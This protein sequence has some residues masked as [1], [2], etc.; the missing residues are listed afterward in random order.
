MPIGG[1]NLLEP[2][3]LGIAAL[4]GPYNFNAVDIAE[5]LAA[6]GAVEILPDADALAPALIRLLNDPDERARRGAAGLN[7]VA[8]SREPCSA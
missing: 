5:L 3:S 7:T 2:A 4:T 1:H 8:T 6:S